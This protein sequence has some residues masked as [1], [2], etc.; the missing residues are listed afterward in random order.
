MLNTLQSYFQYFD[1]FNNYLGNFIIT[2][3]NFNYRFTL[4]DIYDGCII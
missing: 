1:N 4:K 2:Y 3:V